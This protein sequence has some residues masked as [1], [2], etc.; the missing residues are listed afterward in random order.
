MH[1]NKWT[2]LILLAI[3]SLCSMSVW[4]S[5]S[6]VVPALKHE[7][8]ISDTDAAWITQAVQ[9]G[10]VVGTLVS[11][12]LNLSDIFNARH[13]FAVSSLIAAAANA[14]LAHF[15]HSPTS[16]I[17]FR[18]FTGMCIAGVYPPAMKIAATWFRESRGFAI[19]VLIGA[20]AIG[21]GTPY[22]MNAIGSDSWRTNMLFIALLPL[23]AAVLILML[24]N[25]PFTPARAVFDIRQVH[26][27][28]RNRGV[29]L[30]NYGYFGHMWELYAMWTW[31]PVMI[32][33]SMALHGAAPEYA[34]IASFLVIFSGAAGSIAA[35]LLADRVGR[36]LVTSWAMILSGSCC[37]MIGFLFGKEEIAMLTIAIIW[38][39]TVVADSAQFSTSVTELGDPQYIG[40]ALTL[41]TSIGF[42]LT[43]IPIY[44]IP[45]LVDH[46]GWR[47]AFIALA[48][49]PAFGVYSMLKLRALPE[50]VKIA[51]GKR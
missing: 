32:R 19:G 11:A 30:A 15:S 20:L 36:T 8:G 6:A 40:T 12:I 1:Q 38:G 16:A 37:I 35:G 31:A 41:Q 22:L 7:W 2:A 13:L 24:H 4:F 34:E 45:V 10:F 17:V 42:L 27:V 39:A 49:G 43:T 23:I 51:G 48:P 26:N 25:G 9:I 44:L 33:A 14:A 46:F 3:A 29:R 18:F 28:L 50:A 21:K 5:G 47:Y